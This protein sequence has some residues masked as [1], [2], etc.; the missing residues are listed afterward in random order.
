MATSDAKLSVM[1]VDGSNKRLLT[2]GFDRS[3]GNPVWSADG[4]SIYV[5]YDEH[6]SNRVAR[7]GLDGSVRDVATGLTGSGLDRPYSGGEF[8][9][10]RGGAVAVTAGDNLHPSDVGDRFGRSVRHLTH[11]NEQL[12]AKV[13]GQPQKLRGH[14]ELRPAPD[15][16]VDDHSRPTSTRPSAIR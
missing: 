14:V 6:G 9:V 7:V 12:Q 8:S 2:A 13:L 3:V 15:R 5:L 10:S 11:L 4:R 1:N 16:R